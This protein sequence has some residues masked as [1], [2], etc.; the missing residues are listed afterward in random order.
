MP[1]PNSGCWLW[2]AGYN[3]K[4][5]YGHF[6]N[7]GALLY[8]H[9]FAYEQYVGPIPK[10]ICVCHKCDVRCCVNPA[11]LFLGTKAE[12]L[13]DMA[14]KGRAS[15][16]AHRWSAKLSDEVVRIIRKS[17]KTNSELARVYGVSPSL[18]SGIRHG[19]RWVHA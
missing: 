18:I 11:H 9:R 4:T 16:G 8:A 12:N 7:R 6:Y 2:T 14:R 1:E 13:S 5:G 3:P 19:H 15:R 17:A 10:N